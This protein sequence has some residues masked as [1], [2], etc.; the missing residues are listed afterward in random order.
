MNSETG[1]LEVAKTVPADEHAGGLSRLLLIFLVST[2]VVFVVT[3]LV[4]GMP[5]AWVA[6]MS[7]GVCCL[8]AI[9]G[10]FLSI[11]PRGEVYRVARLYQS[12]AV[13]IGPPVLYLFVC[14]NS[15][16]ELFSRGMVYFVF[17]FYLVGLLTE[18]MVQANRFKVLK[19]SAGSV[20]GHP[21]N[22]ESQT[23]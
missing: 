2:V 20:L 4:W 6:L 18:V 11:F 7:A 9:A 14:K 13:R 12:M 22:G 3:L 10:H 16:Q 8:A 1:N 5:T 21:T 23:G 15:F 19:S 17:L